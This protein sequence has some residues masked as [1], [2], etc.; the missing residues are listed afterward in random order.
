VFPPSAAS[1]SYLADKY[2]VSSADGGEDH[3]GS[4]RS[5]HITLN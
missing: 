2:S 5:I 1:G 3:Q 4:L